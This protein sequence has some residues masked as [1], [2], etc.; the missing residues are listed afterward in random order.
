[1]KPQAFEFSTRR[2]SQTFEFVR[3]KRL[4]NSYP[5]TKRRSVIPD[6]TREVGP[7]VWQTLKS[8]IKATK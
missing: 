7:I 2:E 5:F 6:N 3:N 4:L 8:V 1:M